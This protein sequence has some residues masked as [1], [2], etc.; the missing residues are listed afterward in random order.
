MRLLAALVACLALLT[1]CVGGPSYAGGPTEEDPH[2]V[3]I[4][5]E[6]V[7]VFFVDGYA[8]ESK[9]STVYVGPGRHR[10]RVRLQYH[11]DSESGAPQEMKDIDLHVE[12]GDV[13][14]LSR[15]GEGQFGP[16]DVEVKKAPRR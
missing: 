12:D 6:D 11:I 16:F 2:G 7:F 3:I 5:G 9:S 1:G 15:T 4:P 14:L 8:V 10:V 13:F